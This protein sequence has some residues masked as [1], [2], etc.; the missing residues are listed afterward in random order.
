MLARTKILTPFDPKTAT[1]SRPSTPIPNIDHLPTTSLDPSLIAPSLEPEATRGT[2][3]EFGS[4]ISIPNAARQF[5]SFGIVES[6]RRRKIYA[7]LWANTGAA[8]DYAVQADIEFWRQDS[9]V[10]SLPLGLALSAA[11]AAI[12]QDVPNCFPSGGNVV[13]DSIAIYLAQPTA[14]QPNSVILQPQYVIVSADK[15][16]VS[17]NKSWIGIG[18]SV[19][20]ARCFVGV[21]SSEI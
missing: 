6:L 8:T 2:R 13:D 1:T 7:Y 12:A 14:G 11:S 4:V 17:F 9:L 16:T 19:T 18:A 10:G 20:A 3:F 15:V 21:L 5:I